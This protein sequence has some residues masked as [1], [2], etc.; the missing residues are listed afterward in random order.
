MISSSLEY[1]ENS[2][3]ERSAIG[4]SCCSDHVFLAD[5]L[6]GLEDNAEVTDKLIATLEQDARPDVDDVL[7]PF[8]EHKHQISMVIQRRHGRIERLETDPVMIE[9]LRDQ[10]QALIVALPISR[11]LASIRPG[12]LLWRNGSVFHGPCPYAGHDFDEDSFQIYDDDFAWCER[13]GGGNLFRVIGLVEALPSPQEQVSRAAEIAGL[14]LPDASPD[15]SQHRSFPT[16][17]HRESG[18]K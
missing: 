7:R 13:C 17:L 10:A 6:Q 11:Y 1:H 3:M 14:P 4:E 15:R 2:D 12:I 16:L 5:S 18:R 8:R 9:E